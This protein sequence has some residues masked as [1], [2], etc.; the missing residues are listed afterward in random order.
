ME[1]GGE[2]RA[3]ASCSMRSAALMNRG[4]KGQRWPNRPETRA[5]VGTRQVTAK[6]TVKIFEAAAIALRVNSLHCTLTIEW[7]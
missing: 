5:N 2:T 4:S 6:M 7:E 3:A 1:K